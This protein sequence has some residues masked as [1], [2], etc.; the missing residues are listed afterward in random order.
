MFL[1]NVIKY[2]VDQ[3]IPSSFFVRDILVIVH[4]HGLKSVLFIKKFIDVI[5]FLQDKNDHTICN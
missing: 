5:H 3:E 4:N 1:E 2:V